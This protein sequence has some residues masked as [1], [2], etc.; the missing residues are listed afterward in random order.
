MRPAICIFTFGLVLVFGFSGCDSPVINESGSPST[1]QTAIGDASKPQLDY[2]RPL[3]GPAGFVSV[4]DNPYFPLPVGTTWYYEGPSDGASETI[5]VTVTNQTQNIMGVKTTVVLDRV[6]A[7]GDLTE[8]TLDF[9]AQDTVGNV[10]YFG[11]NTTTLENGHITGHE[12]R[13]RAGDDEAQAGIIMEAAPQV[14][15]TY[16]EEYLPG[17]AEDQATVI[18]LDETVSVEYGHFEHC[19]KTDNFTALEPDV[20]E[21][22]W[23]APGIGLVMDMVTTGGTERHG[24][25]QILYR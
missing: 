23:Y 13:W 24:L 8:E 14:G 3:P 1:P 19:L 18:S 10:W 9:Y 4:I 22:K 2:S 21:N 11:E 16:R 5:Q 20:L 7:S 17:V 15:D 12:G 6:Y 25:V